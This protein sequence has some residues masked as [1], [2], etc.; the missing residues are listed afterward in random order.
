MINI[1]KINNDVVKKNLIITGATSGIGGA[2]VDKVDKQVNHLIFIG[3]SSEKML[4]LSKRIKTSCSI[5]TVD[6]VDM[7]KLAGILQQ[8]PARIDGFV[9]AA[10]VESVEPIKLVDYKKFDNL[11]R[12]HV[13]AFVEILKFIEKNKKRTDE[14]FTSVVAV[15]S[16]ASDNGGVGQTMY[17]SSKAALEAAVRVLSKEMV[18]K[19]I[20]INA[21]KP[22]IVDTDMTQRW[23]RRI[24]I[25]NFADI[26]KM[27]LNGVVQPEEVASLI[28]FLLS[29]QARHIVGTQIKIDGGG[30]SGKIY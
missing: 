3:R 25:T 29:D 24:G 10:G 28:E 22:G 13:Y 21:V 2:L 26:E 4:E 19:R 7:D 30:P 17:A 11:M 8:L 15:S 6:L 9:H 5:L 12:V 18:S 16:I 23:M 27:Q 20:R 14:Y 1:K